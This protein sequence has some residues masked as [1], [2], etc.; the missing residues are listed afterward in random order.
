MSLTCPNCSAQNDESYRFCANCGT[1]LQ[2]GDQPTPPAAASFY[3]DSSKPAITIPTP[4]SSP[5]PT[6]Y[7]GFEKQP[8]SQPPAYAVKTSPDAAASG[9]QAPTMPINTF[10]PPIPVAPGRPG[11]APTQSAPAQGYQAYAPGA[12]GRKDGGVYAPYNAGMTG[13]LEK[14]KDP[15]SWLMP[16]IVLAAL[17][18]LALGVVSAYLMLN[19]PGNNAPAGINNTVPGVSNTPLPGAVAPDA[20]ATTGSGTA[21]GGTTGGGT[22]AGGE[23][24]KVR[25]VIRRSNEQQIQAWRELNTDLLKDTYTGQALDENVNM[26]TQLQKQGM[27]AIPVNQRLDILNVSVKG[28][29]ATARTLEVWTVTFYTKADNKKG[30]SKGPDTLNE[31]YH[32]VKQNGKWLISSLDIAGDGPTPTPGI[33]N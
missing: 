22:T 32:L 21:G 4:S 17:V 5:L 15:R 25:D 18:L 13:A 6:A 19:K 1:P 27:Y 29:T 28:D 3:S 7:G 8:A 2:R 12:S 11:E 33:G 31:T 9:P 16:V 30:D 14:Q 24:E 26:V 20:T 10:Q 23:E